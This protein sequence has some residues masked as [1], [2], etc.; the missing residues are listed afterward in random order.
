MWVVW[1]F[2]IPTWIICMIG[3]FAYC[4]FDEYGKYV[5]KA[6]DLIMFIILLITILVFWISVID[7]V[8]TIVKDRDGDRILG[9]IGKIIGCGLFIF[10]IGGAFIKSYLM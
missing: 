1:V 8:K 10:F 7:L 5:L 4:M 9:D 3:L 6:F 2:T